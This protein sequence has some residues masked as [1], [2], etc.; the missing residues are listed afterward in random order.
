MRF[1][2]GAHD[3]GYTL[4]ECKLFTGRTHQIR[5]H[6]QY[7]RHP[8]VGDPVYSANGPKDPRAQLG[9]ERQF[10]HSYS[11]GLDHPMTGEPLA[12]ADNLP[13]D[14]RVALESLADRSRGRTEAGDEVAALLADAPVPSVEGV[15][16]GEA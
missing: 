4:I 13:R 1:E 3:D 16:D 15:V 14:L 8:I 5:V 7:T 10:L 12:F 2:A 11:L 6:M 9:L